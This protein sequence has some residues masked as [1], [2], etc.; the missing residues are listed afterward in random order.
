M[1]NLQGLRVKMF[2]VY[3]IYSTKLSRFYTGSTSKNPEVR[4]E[5]HNSVYYENKFTERGI[6]WTLFL[7][8]ECSS[9]K[10]AERI[11]HH[12]KKMKSKVFMHNLKKYPEMVQKLLD[13]L[14]TH[15]QSSDSYRSRFIPCGTTKTKSKPL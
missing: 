15:N 6:P 1:K 2:W 4:L 9:R 10:Q 13:S 3:I 12:I 14:L 8:I 5:M 7:T 11:E